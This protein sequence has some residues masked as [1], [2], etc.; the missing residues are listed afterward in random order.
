MSKPLSIHTKQKIEKLLEN[1]GDM[2]L[3][4]RARRIVEELNPQD[5]EKILDVGCGDGYYLYLLSNLGIKLS[6][7]GA[8]FDKRALESARKNLGSKKVRLVWAD[9]MKRLPFE[10]KTFDKIVM[11]EVVEHL[12]DDVK[13]LKEVRRVLKPGGILVLTVPNANYPFL[14]DPVNWTLEHLFGTHVESGFWAGIWNQHLRLYKLSQ[15]QKVITKSGLKID[16]VESVTFWC[17]P[18][19][20]YLINIGARILASTGGNT[21]IIKGANKFKT[22]VN[23]SFLIKTFFF[24]SNL[25]DKLNGIWMPINEGV[26]V[27]IF[28][29]K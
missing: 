22:G 15:I 11:S 13:G 19:N 17:L 9:L 10:D 21:K 23:K 16:K 3:K 28:T 26:G 1:T 4:R 2:A 14:W 27:L 29:E 8:D 25:I 12:P 18:F 20:H 7:T 6:L 24:A 5:S